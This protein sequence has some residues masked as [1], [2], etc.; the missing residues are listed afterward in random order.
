MKGRIKAH[1]SDRDPH[2]LTRTAPVHDR[3]MLGVLPRAAGPGALTPNSPSAEKSVIQLGRCA[4]MNAPHAG[5][6]S[7]S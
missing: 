1:L 3:A 5:V 6:A 4:E 2:L 7:S